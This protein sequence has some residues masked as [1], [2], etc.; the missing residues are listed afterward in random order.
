MGTAAYMSPEQALGATNA[1][2]RSDIFSLGM[3]DVSFSCC[4]PSKRLNV[5]SNY[6]PNAASCA[7]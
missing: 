5:R 1:D 4:S 6:I 2:A 7:E 3:I